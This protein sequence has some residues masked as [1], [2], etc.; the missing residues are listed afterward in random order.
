MHRE[1]ESATWRN[2]YH[3]AGSGFLYGLSRGGI[4]NDAGAEKLFPEPED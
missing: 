2:R 1:L 3:L 4:G